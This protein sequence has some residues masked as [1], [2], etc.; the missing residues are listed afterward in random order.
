MRRS[1]WT[2]RPNATVVLLATRRAG[3]KSTANTAKPSGNI[4]KP[5]IGKK[6]AQ[7]P[8]HKAPPSPIR[9]AL[10]RGKG[11]EYFPKRARCGGIVLCSTPFMA[12][13]GNDFDIAT[14]WGLR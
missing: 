8:I 1:R 14:A 5:S 12:L 11:T 3:G 9:S 7:P 13:G 6:P 10:E 2:A 4:Q